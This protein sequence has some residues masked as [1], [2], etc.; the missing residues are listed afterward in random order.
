MAI[1]N[2]YIGHYPRVDLIA[3][4]FFFISYRGPWP[5]G[6]NHLRGPYGNGV[7]WTNN[8]HIYIYNNVRS[9]P[10]L[11]MVHISQVSM[12]MTG[13]MVFDIVILTLVR[14]HIGQSWW[15]WMTTAQMAGQSWPLGSDFSSPLYL[16]CGGGGN[17]INHSQTQFYAFIFHHIPIFMALYPASCSIKIPLFPFHNQPY[18]HEN[19]YSFNS[20]ITYKWINRYPSGNLT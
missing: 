12:V 9:H 14:I 7:D 2:S 3:S 1:F 16:W 10:W 13:W 15:R 5:T 17:C 11:G 19:Y 8:V 4:P 18:S 20:N 6:P